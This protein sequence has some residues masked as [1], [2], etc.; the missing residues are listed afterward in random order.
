MFNRCHAFFPKD[1]INEYVFWVAG[2]SH[3]V[4]TDEDD[5]DNI[6]KILGLQIVM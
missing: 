6:S 5:I 2:V 4:I 1:I 3:A